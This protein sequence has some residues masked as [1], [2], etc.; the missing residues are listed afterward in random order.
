VM[1][2]L[3]AAPAAPVVVGLWWG[4]WWDVSMNWNESN[5]CGYKASLTN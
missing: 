5:G 1:L 3:V 2:L 4:W